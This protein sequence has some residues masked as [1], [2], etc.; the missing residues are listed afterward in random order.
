MS[1][2]FYIQKSPLLSPDVLLLFCRVTTVLG[3]MD[4][5][6]TNVVSEFIEFVVNQKLCQKQWQE[7]TDQCAELTTRCDQVQH[8]NEALQTK[9]KHARSV[10]WLSVMSRACLDHLTK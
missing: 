7:A 4:V 8:E 1:V 9:L 3:F 5:C 6:M 2:L 10:H